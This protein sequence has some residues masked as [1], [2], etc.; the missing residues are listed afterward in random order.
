MRYVPAGAAYRLVTWGTPIALLF[1]P[2]YFNRAA[3]NMQHVLGPEVGPRDARR[4]AHEAFVNYGRYMVDLLR[5]PHVQTS[6]LLRDVDIRGWENVDKAFGHGRG[7]VFVTGHIGNWDMAGAVLVAHGRDVSVLVETLKPARWNERVQR[8]REHVG[9]KA[10]P[11][12]SGLRDMLAVLRCKEGLAI[13]VDRPVDR[14]GV[15]VTFFGRQTH[16]PAGAATL[17]VRTGAPVLPAVLVRNDE[18]GGYLLHIGEPI[19]REATGS[20]ARDVEV[21]SQRV[22]SWLEEMIRRYPD[23]WYMFRSMW[24]G[25]STF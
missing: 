23:Q 13:L 14:N 9:M 22:M 6:D 4:L 11:I 24:P 3:S 18:T 25:A 21:L 5:L 15:L 10:I 17:A 19:L 2:G 8:I 12:E 7:V 1:A 16:V 20:V